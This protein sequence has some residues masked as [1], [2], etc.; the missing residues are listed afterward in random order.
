MQ[1]SIGTFIAIA[2][3]GEVGEGTPTNT[4]LPAITSADYNIGTT[5]TVS[6]GTWTGATSLAG[7]LRHVSDDT[8]I[9]TFTA[10]GTYLL[11]DTD[12]GEELYIHV[13]AQPGGVEAAGAAVGAVELADAFTRANGDL[14]NGWTHTASKWTITSN[15]L[16]ASP[17]VG[18][19]LATNGGMESGNPPTGITTPSGA[20]LSAN[21]DAHSGSQSLSVVRGSSNSAAVK[22]T[23]ITAKQF[24]RVSFWWKRVTATQI[25][26]QMGTGYRGTTTT[27]WAEVQGSGYDNDTTWGHIFE[28]AGASGEALFDDYSLKQYTR[29]DLFATRNLGTPDVRVSVKLT[30]ITIHPAG[31]IVCADSASN[32]QN[33]IMVLLSPYDIITTL[34]PRIY[35]YKVV[36]GTQTQLAEIS[37]GVTYGAGRVLA[38]EHSNTTVRVFYN[39]AQVGI[40]YTVS[41]A[42]I[43]SNTIHGMVNFDSS[44]TLDDFT[45]VAA[46]DI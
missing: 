6:L 19:E 26:S 3:Q 5:I 35:L 44:N 38:L 10:D 46:P 43:I 18:A 7:S 22:S 8:E 32:P 29:A 40:D 31:L 16:T 4:V 11:A 21:V 20:T 45:A 39:G 2:C 23:T 25:N 28:V 24:H 1:I 36:A 30:G 15:A 13:T 12:F 9:D 34:T 41:D 14:G 33:Y 27:S 42:G 17:A 37:A